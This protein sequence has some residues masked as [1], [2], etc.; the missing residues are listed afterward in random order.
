MGAVVQLVLDRSCGLGIAGPHA[1]H[2]QGIERRPA[3]NTALVA[4][5]APTH[6]LARQ[7]GP[8]TV[9]AFQEHTQLVLT[10]RSPLTDGQDHGVLSP[11]TWRLGD[12]SA[13]HALLRAGLGWGNMPE[14]MVRE[15][16]RAGRLTRLTLVEEPPAMFPL[17][18]IHRSDTPPGPA[19]RW[20]ADR[21]AQ[22]VP[23][24]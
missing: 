17:L 13:K 15:D 20:L 24:G 22:P 7:P 18:L 10:D 5:A 14:P 2:I 3:G 11:R 4:C 23:A 6:P 9:A 12:L 21:L 16:L 8:L 1:L 19:A